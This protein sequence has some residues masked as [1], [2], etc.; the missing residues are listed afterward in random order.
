LEK[1]KSTKERSETFQKMSLFTYALLCSPFAD[2][3]R[4][5]KVFRLDKVPAER[6]RTAKETP[7]QK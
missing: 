4:L 7:L 5:D 6:R 2:F 3:L 1:L